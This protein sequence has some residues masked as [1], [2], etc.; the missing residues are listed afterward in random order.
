MRASDKGLRYHM[1]TNPACTGL[2]EVI[3]FVGEY[4]RKRKKPDL[5]EGSAVYAERNTR[6]AKQNHVL[7]EHNYTSVRAPVPIAVALRVG[8][9][10]KTNLHDNAVV[11]VHTAIWNAMRGTNWFT[12]N[13]IVSRQKQLFTE[14]VAA[15]NMTPMNIS[16]CL[17]KIGLT[18]R[19]VMKG[20]THVNDVVT[21]LNPQDDLHPNVQQLATIDDLDMVGLTRMHLLIRMSAY[22]SE[23]TSCQPYYCGSN[24]NQTIFS[25]VNCEQATTDPLSQ[26]VIATDFNLAGLK[27]ICPRQFVS[28]YTHQLEYFEIVPNHVIG[29]RTNKFG[30]IVQPENLLHIKDVPGCQSKKCEDMEDFLQ[31]F[32]EL[33][34][35]MKSWF[36]LVEHEPI[37]RV[38]SLVSNTK[39]NR[40]KL[41]KAKRMMGVGTEVTIMEEVNN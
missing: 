16:E 19:P 37:Q 10:F 30:N 2:P 38:A 33:P 9:C 4:A 21:S 23:G 8:D 35:E 6:R 31:E 40:R 24:G 1:L 7:Y 39:R 3:K 22:K 28:W 32:D 36:T 25:G 29:S 20:W 18:M 26:T 15:G 14:L 12:D 17:A 11:E 41:N 27:A 13:T 34:E 5:N